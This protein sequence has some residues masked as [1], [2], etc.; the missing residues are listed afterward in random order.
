MEYSFLKTRS[1]FAHFAQKLLCSSAALSMSLLAGIA[2]ETALAQID[3]GRQSNPPFEIIYAGRQAAARK[4]SRSV[5][6]STSA[7]DSVNAAQKAPPVSRRD[8]AKANVRGTSPL[9]ESVVADIDV[10]TL[11]LVAQSRDAWQRGL[12]D[13][14]SYAA[15]LDIATTTQLKIARHQNDAERVIR[16]LKI[17]ATVWDEAT[18]RLADFNQPASSGWQADLQHAQLMS[19]RARLQHSVALGHPLTDQDMRVYN[20]LA[21]RH[22]DQRREDFHAGEGSAASVLAAARLVDEQL[23]V[24]KADE[25][26]PSGSSAVA[27]PVFEMRNTAALRQALDEIHRPVFLA[28][29]PDAVAFRDHAEDQAEIRRATQLVAHLATSSERRNSVHFLNQL[30]Q[31]AEAILAV[32]WE[33]FQS[34]TATP[35]GMVRQ[36]W[37]HDSLASTVDAE[38]TTART[39]Q[40][41]QKQRLAQIRN[42]VTSLRDRRGRNSADVA[43]AEVLWTVEQLN[44]QPLSRTGRMTPSPAHQRRESHP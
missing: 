21:A 15:W 9:A 14:A 22:L 35:G 32:Q 26:D 33:R 36:W 37:L 23:A 11:R 29:Y 30:D 41:A 12:M 39:F 6:T 16:T 42:A 17:Q 7:Q 3:P 18:K 34:G 31:N 40:E 19:L 44:L 5:A 20:R 25:T 10:K 8:A 27:V 2:P 24:P 1:P 13:N 43:A 4:T 28:T 38:G